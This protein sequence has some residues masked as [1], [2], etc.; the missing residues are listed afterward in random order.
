[1][2]LLIHE[3]FKSEILIDNKLTY[4]VIENQKT[5]FK[6]MTDLNNQTLNTVDNNESFAILQNEEKLDLSKTLILFTDLFNFNVN[7]RR[8][9]NELFRKI[10]EDEASYNSQL[11]IN[12]INENVQLY[13]KNIFSRYFINVTYLEDIEL[14]DFLKL[15][16]VEI[17]NEG[18]T[19]LETLINWLTS[20][21]ELTKI[22]NYAFINLSTFLTVEDLKELE[23]ICEYH[24][25]SIIL[26][27]NNILNLKN[28]KNI[29]VIDDDLCHLII[30]NM[31]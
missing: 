24:K 14:N 25:I 18:E 3:Y 9:K 4:V 8:I 22:T 10:T 11:D 28:I 29:N 5:F 30:D 13:F 6:M 12:V 23:K 27:E 16:K 17:C 21:T 31:L 1:M 20:F 19:L 7:S 26:F 15:Y 2:K